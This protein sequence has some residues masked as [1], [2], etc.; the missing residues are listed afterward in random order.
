VLP[1]AVI[2]DDKVLLDPHVVGIKNKFPCAN[3]RP[4]LTKGN[5]RR[6]EKGGNPVEIISFFR[7]LS[8]PAKTGKWLWNPNGS[9][10]PPNLK[11][12]L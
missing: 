4:R 9:L 8:T 5:A 12:F 3:E 6:K 2:V 7:I 1:Q 11:I 10:E